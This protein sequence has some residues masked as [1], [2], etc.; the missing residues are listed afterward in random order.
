MFQHFEVLVLADGKLRRSPN[1]SLPVVVNLVRVDGEHLTL[2]ASLLLRVLHPGKDGA[3][4]ICTQHVITKEKV[5]PQVI[6][7]QNICMADLFGFL[8][9]VFK[10]LVHQGDKSFQ[11]FH[12]L[13]FILLF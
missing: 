8:D 6:L 4:G 9:L 3:T 12:F 5:L 11:M 10:L 2:G 7:G 13:A 1:K